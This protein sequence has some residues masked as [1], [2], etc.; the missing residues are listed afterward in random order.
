M[1]QKETGINFE[2]GDEVTTRK[3]DAQTGH[4]GIGII[5]EFSK[6]KDFDAVNV[7]CLDGTS[8][9]YLLQNLIKLKSEKKQ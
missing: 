1:I 7:K 5:K 4:K 9:Q 6:W 8:H 2:I 3:G